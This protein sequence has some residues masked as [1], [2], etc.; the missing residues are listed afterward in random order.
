MK[1]QTERMNRTLKEA[2]G[3]RYHYETHRQL[4]DH[5][6][7]FLDAYNFAR[8]L[9]A[10]RGLTPYEHVCNARADEP[11]WFK[12]DPTHLTLGPNSPCKLSC[13]RAAGDRARIGK[14][15]DGFVVIA[16]ERFQDVAGI[17]AQAPPAPADR[18]GAG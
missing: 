18:A 15:V 13:L 16:R 11:H 5:L 6:A 9:K 10:L 4:K 1:R 17:L 8:R 3:R 12:Y 7:A 2:T 14:R